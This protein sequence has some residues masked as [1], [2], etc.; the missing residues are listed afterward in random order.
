MELLVFRGTKEHWTRESEKLLA[1]YGPVVTFWLATKP[2]VVISDID[3]ARDAFRRNDIA[4][5]PKDIICK[6]CER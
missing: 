2:V 6:C 3:I 4:G 1:K 5:R